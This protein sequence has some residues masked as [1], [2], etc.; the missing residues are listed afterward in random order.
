[1]YSANQYV[2]VAESL[3]CVQ[4]FSMPWTAAHQASLSITISLFSRTHVH[5]V[6]DAIQPSHPQSLPSPLVLNFSQLQILFQ[7]VSSSH[8]VA[9][10]LELQ[11]QHHFLPI[12]I[13][14][15]FPSIFT[16]LISLLSKGLSRVFSSTTVQ[17]CQFFSAQHSLW[18]NSHIHTW[19]LEKPQLWL[20]R[21]L[22]AKWCLCFLKHCLGLT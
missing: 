2:V 5:W 7:W 15:W 20:Y 14:D 16:G 11:L 12:N 10:V 13:Q 22:L 21:P 3:S 8:Q 17:K 4:F 9:E 19:L 1:M 18:S 6:S